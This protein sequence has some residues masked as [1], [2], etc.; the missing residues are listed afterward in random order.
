MHDEN[1]DK[2]TDGSGKVKS[3][4]LKQLLGFTFDNGANCLEYSGI[5]IPTLSQALRVCCDFMIVPVIEIKDL[6]DEGIEKTIKLIKEAELPN[7]YIIQS[8]DK[9][10][11]L[12]VAD[13]DKD[14]KLWLLSSK[15]D[16]EAVDFVKETK[17]V[18]GIAFDAHNSHNDA[19]TIADVMEQKIELKA[20]TVD[21]ADTLTAMYNAGVREFITDCI[22]P[23]QP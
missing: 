1:V 11:L 13:I 2:M 12:A 10:V 3:F 20:W 5:K 8:F 9:D 23:V 18:T 6:S 15:L 21:D 19:Q 14:A 16:N 22:L 4:T 7:G 17:Q